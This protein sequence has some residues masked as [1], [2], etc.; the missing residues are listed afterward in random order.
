MRKLLLATALLAATVVACD[1]KDPSGPAN[2]TVTGPSPFTTTSTTS[3]TTS[4]TT[5]V[6]STSTST[7]TSVPFTLARTYIALGQTLPTMPSTLSL[8]LRQLFAAASATSSWRD[9]L[10]I[11][12]PAADPQF[13]VLGFYTTPNGGGGAVQGTLD[14]TLEDGQFTGTL[15]NVT[16][17]CTAE[18]QFFGNVN[19]QSLQ[20]FGGTTLRDCKGNPLNFPSFTMIA[21][22]AP[23]PVAPPTVVTTTIPLTCGYSL[24]ASGASFDVNGGIGSVD[25]T[26]GPSCVWTLQRFVDWVTLQPAGAT[27]P[28]K[29]S[30]VVAP[31]PGGP[32]STTVII[33][34]QPFQINQSNV[35]TTTTAPTTSSTSTTTTTTTTIAPSTTTS[36]TTTSSTTTS[37]SCSYGLNPTSLTVSAS[38]Q[39][40]NVN[41]VTQAGCGWTINLDTFPSWIVLLTAASGNGPATVSLDIDEYALSESCSAR[42]ASLQIANNSLPVVQNCSDDGV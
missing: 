25:V 22:A 17:E 15:T 32:R 1:T 21:T 42:K 19:S 40:R 10:P 30:F 36:S 2:V 12:G 11:F 16:P 34:G 33:A 29:V 8:S 14:G 5:S 23:P 20:W 35:T 18:R 4:P 37:S 9:Y 38:R 7:T 27:G 26:T 13:N 3:T 39:T 24:S 6:P 28:A 31:N 41:I